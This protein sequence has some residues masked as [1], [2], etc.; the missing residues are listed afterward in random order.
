MTDMPAYGDDSKCAI[1]IDEGL[2]AGLA[3]NAAS[4]V[5]LTL[6]RRVDGL[7][8]ADVVDSDDYIHPG[9]THIS[10]P[11]LKASR[12][13]LR[14]LHAAAAACPTVFVVGF[15]GLAQACRAY[16]E[17]IAK[18]AEAAT[19]SLSFVGLGLFGDKQSLKRYTGSLA[20]WR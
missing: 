12:E 1:V 17:Y 15:T 10:V 9:I 6:G 11:V 19:E 20:L 18:M 3:L 16:D 8:G 4:V 2:S 5:A 7:I 14:E 13:R